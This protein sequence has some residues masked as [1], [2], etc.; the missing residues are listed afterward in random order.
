MNLNHSHFYNRSLFQFWYSS[1]STKLDRILWSEIN[2][3]IYIIY[4][5]GHV[6]LLLPRTSS[7]H[8]IHAYITQKNC[9]CHIWQKNIALTRNSFVSALKVARFDLVNLGFA[10]NALHL[11]TGQFHLTTPFK[12][13]PDALDWRTR[14]VVIEKSQID[15]SGSG[16]I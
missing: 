10:I 11:C 5:A 4:H 9:L 15:L 14:V 1:I 13:A 3:E 12:D 16:T 6:R 2:S 7:R 8:F